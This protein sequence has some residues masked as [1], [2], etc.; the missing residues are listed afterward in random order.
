MSTTHIWHRKLVNEFV[1]IV[2]EKNELKKTK[3][4]KTK[5]YTL[6]TPLITNTPHPT[7]LLP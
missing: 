1:M 5:Q 7:S 3:Q 2:L 4:N 6:P